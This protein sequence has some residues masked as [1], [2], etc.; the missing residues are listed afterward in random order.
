MR[1]A[2]HRGSWTQVISQA[3]STS[4][5]LS[6]G[7]FIEAPGR[8]RRAP[9]GQCRRPGAGGPSSRRLPVGAAEVLVLQVAALDRAAL[10]R[11]MRTVNAYRTVTEVA[12]PD[13]A[14]LHRGAQ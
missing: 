8:L 13:R 14:A 4:P 7:P 3:L 10:H 6:G 1:A 2:L 9:R 5:S 11:G 12:A